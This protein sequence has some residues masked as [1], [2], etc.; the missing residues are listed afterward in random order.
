MGAVYETI[1]AKN[2]W[3]VGNSYKANGIMTTVGG[4][5]AFGAVVVSFIFNP[6]WSSII[7]F[8]SSFFLSQ[9][10]IQIFR[11]S[12]QIIILL[13]LITSLAATVYFCF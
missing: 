7:V 1:A 2:G 12:S 5:A 11:A 8:V 9:T 10:I 3:P 4:F 6:W 13:L